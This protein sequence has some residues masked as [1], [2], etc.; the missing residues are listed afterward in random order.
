MSAS[1]CLWDFVLHLSEKIA[2]TQG[3]ACVAFSSAAPAAAFLSLKESENKEE[4]SPF[5]FL[6]LLDYFPLLHI[7]AFAFENR[8]RNSLWIKCGSLCTC[9][10]GTK[11]N[12][13]LNWWRG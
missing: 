1:L 2:H 12:I 13:W 3:M 8:S 7:G 4:K 5:F 11:R 6:F 9:A 10:I